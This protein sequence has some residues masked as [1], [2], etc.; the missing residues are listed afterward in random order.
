MSEAEAQPHF[1]SENWMA[2]FVEKFR[3]FFR[4][5]LAPTAKVLIATFE[6]QPEKRLCNLGGDGCSGSLITMLQ[7]LGIEISLRDI[8]DVQRIDG[9]SNLSKSLVQIMVNLPFGSRVNLPKLKNSLNSDGLM[10]IDL[11]IRST[12]K[13]KRV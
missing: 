8:S 10:V 13:L 9:I 1:E 2:R 7:R 3:N 5:L 12:R 11:I 6:I 4:E